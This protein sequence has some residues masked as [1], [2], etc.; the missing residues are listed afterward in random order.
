MTSAT[1]LNDCVA[2]TM[3]FV[4]QLER[5]RLTPLVKSIFNAA[6]SGHS[7]VFIPGI[8]IAEILYLSEKKELNYLYRM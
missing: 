2:D 1:R 3:A 6:E 8:V 4:L 7:I 5:R